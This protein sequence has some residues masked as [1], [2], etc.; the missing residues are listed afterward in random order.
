MSAGPG[1]ATRGGRW[2]AEARPGSG[3]R[4]RLRAPLLALL[5]AACAPT[6]YTDIEYA[7]GQRRV[8]RHGQGPVQEGDM[9]GRVL[10]V[11]GPPGEVLPSP[12]GDIFAYRLRYI[13]LQLIQINSGWIAPVGMPL[14]ARADG[15]REDDTLMV[16]FDEEGRVRQLA[17]A[18]ADN[19]LVLPRRNGP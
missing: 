10:D 19:P 9:K 11:L 8:P 1:P 17:M 6:I 7:V 4:A 2:P 3:A 18:R 5:L 12:R 14:W 15:L 13:D 16:F